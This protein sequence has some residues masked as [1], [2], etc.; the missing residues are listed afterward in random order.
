MAVAAI[1]LC[2]PIVARAVAVEIKC[3]AGVVTD[4]S[5]SSGGNNYLRNYFQSLPQ[6]DLR[7]VQR[8]RSLAQQRFGALVNAISGSPPRIFIIKPRTRKTPESPGG[9]RVHIVAIGPSLSYLD[10][11][12]SPIVSCTENRFTLTVT[13]IYN[14]HNMIS[15]SFG[16]VGFRPKVDIAT[17]LLRKDVKFTVRWLAQE[18]GGR[19]LDHAPPGNQPLKYP[20]IVSKTID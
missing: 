1:I 20:F 18:Y 14:A 7:A 11:Y 19:K 15:H 10:T 8:K 2:R 12:D 17:A 5:D 16:F 9:K 6:F 4:I 3:A 13:V